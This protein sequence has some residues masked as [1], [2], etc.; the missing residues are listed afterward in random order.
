MELQ[1]DLNE[2]ESA[3]QDSELFNLVVKEYEHVL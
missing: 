3:T 2:V 1:D